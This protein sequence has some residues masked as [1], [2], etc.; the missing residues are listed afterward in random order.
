MCIWLAFIVAPVVDA[1]TNTGSPTE[2]WLAI[3]AAVVFSVVYVWL[4]LTWW[5]ERTRWRPIVL[6]TVMLAMATVLTVA[7]RP[8]WGFLF[9]Y[10]AAVDGPGRSRPCGGCRPS[11]SLPPWARRAR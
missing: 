1:V 7:D 2:H 3:G 11:S 6:T 9:A 10:V 4:A 5:E 8:S